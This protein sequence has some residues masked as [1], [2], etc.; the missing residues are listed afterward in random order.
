MTTVF[1]NGNILDNLFDIKNVF[2][3]NNLF[4]R[5]NIKWTKIEI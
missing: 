1:G 5:I 4:I 3:R 2:T